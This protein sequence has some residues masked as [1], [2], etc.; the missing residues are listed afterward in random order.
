MSWNGFQIRHKLS[1]QYLPDPFSQSNHKTTP[2]HKSFVNEAIAELLANQCV[3]QV[4]EESYSCSP[5]TVVQNAEGKL[6]LVLNLK[7]LNQFLSQVKF[8]YE[9]LKVTLLMF[10]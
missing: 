4:I 10:A 9:D 5:L 3:K 1:V 6:R 8:K 7:Y 2:V